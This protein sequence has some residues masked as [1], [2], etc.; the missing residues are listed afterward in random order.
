MSNNDNDFKITEVMNA[1]HLKGLSKCSARL[2]IDFFWN[3]SVI[4]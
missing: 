1:F 2:E 4:K 3:V